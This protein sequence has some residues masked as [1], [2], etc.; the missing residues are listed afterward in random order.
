M[1]IGAVAG[2]ALNVAKSKLFTAGGLAFGADVAANTYMGDNLGTSVAKA[3]VTGLM[4]A[5]NPVMATG[6]MGAGL[7]K[8]A[9]FGINRF[10]MQKKQWWNAQYATNNQVGGNYVDSQ[11]A[12]TM[13]QASVQAIQGSKLNARSALGGEAKIM[14]PYSTRR[15]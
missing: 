12:Q 8:D 15:Y 11:R 2:G 7:A 13:R 1:A 14:N 4:F 10:N 5:S 3:S 6:L 9:Y